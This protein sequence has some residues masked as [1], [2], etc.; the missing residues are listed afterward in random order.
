MPT[1]KSAVDLLGDLDEMPGSEA[2]FVRDLRAQGAL[3]FESQ[4]LPTRRNEAWKYTDMSGLAREGLAP[5]PVRELSPTRAREYLARIEPSPAVVHVVLA[6]GRMAGDPV[7]EGELPAGVHLHSLRR[8]LEENPSFLEGR[9]GA[10]ANMDRHPFVALNTAMVQDGLVLHLEPGAVLERPINLIAFNGGGE[11]PEAFHV[12]HLVIAEEGARARIVSTHADLDEGVHFS[13]VVTEVL[14]G[15]AAEIEHY[16]LQREADD[17]WHVSMLAVRQERESRF[18][19]T[20]VS[21]GARVARNEIALLLDGEGASCELSGVSLGGGTRHLDTHIHVD[22][23]RPETTSSENY[24]AVLDDR[25]TGVFTGRVLVREG[26]QKADASQACRTLL[27]S[28]LATVDV[29]PQLEIYADDV[30]CSHGATT[31]RLDPG[32]VFYLRSRGIPAEDAERILTHA[33]AQEV[34]SGV[35]EEE[36][37]RYLRRSV[38]DYLGAHVDVPE[39]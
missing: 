27:L 39:A 38:A 16:E 36:I 21:M 5:A 31:G 33:F 18:R 11:R 28:R 25:S 29:R 7:L 26:S 32:A 37:G 20:A 35:A 9:L 12:R 34:L 22:H 15:P 17:A 3:L 19:S 4:G 8:L 6:R 2:P 1:T 23:A 30:K 13:N 10:C 24:R 14:L